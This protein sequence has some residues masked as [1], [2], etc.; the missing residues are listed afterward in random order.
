M[1]GGGGDPMMA[2]LPLVARIVEE[3]EEKE[4]ATKMI[5]RMFRGGTRR[6]L[7]ASGQI[8]NEIECPSQEE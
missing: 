4:E 5:R 7:P 8:L 3:E 1:E 6:H 2:G